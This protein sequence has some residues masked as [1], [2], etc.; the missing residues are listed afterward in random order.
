MGQDQMRLGLTGGI[1]SGKSTVGRIL[2]ERHGLPLLDADL[3][4]SEALAPGTRTAAQVL[5]HFGGEVGVE[6]STAGSAP[7][8]INR[9]ALGRIVFSDPAERRWLEGLVHPIVRARFAA[10]L[11]RLTDA[12]A[13]VLMIPLLFEAGL[14]GLC[15]EIWLVDCDD[16]QQLRR[17]SARD[18]L[19]EAEA[20]SRV[21]AQWPLARKRPLADVVIDNR[22][23][24][25]ALVDQV[26]RAL[27]AGGRGGGT[28]S[29]S[30]SR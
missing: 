25:A 7:A 13:V 28:V 21:E 8:T 19:T 15:S 12:P 20:R 4:A 29:P 23:T 1:A 10:E 14:E 2:H 11:E 17:L 24:T 16:E 26:A 5:N 9:A 3:F 18:G 27:A 6:G 22:S 30:T